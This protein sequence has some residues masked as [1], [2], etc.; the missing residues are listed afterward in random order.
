MLS[1]LIPAYNAELYLADAIRSA[2]R[3]VPEGTYEVLV[4]D[5]GSLDGTAALVRNLMTRYPALRLIEQAENQGVCAA[6]NRL[7]KALSPKSRYVAF[8]DADD[9][10]LPDALS[11][12]VDLLARQPEMMLTVGKMQIV[13]TDAL[14]SDG[15]THG[16]WPVITGITMSA[17]VF[18]TDLM[19]LVGAFDTSFTHGEDVDYLLRIAE[20][21]HSWQLHDDP[22]FYYRQHGANTTKNRHETR[23]GFLRAALLHAKRRAADPA[24]LDARGL[25]REVDPQ[26]IKRV[27]EILEQT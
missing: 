25:F 10:F 7:L 26:V 24:L 5:D 18:R 27:H 23:R 14:D 6:R 22:V 19:R 1:I 16:D 3:Q 2:T 4:C 11:F 13:P 21:T 8:L 20:H 17:C 15:V 9:M 12:G